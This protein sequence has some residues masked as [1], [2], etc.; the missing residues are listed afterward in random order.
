M[1]NFCCTPSACMTHFTCTSIKNCSLVKLYNKVLIIQL[2]D[3]C[4]RGNQIAPLST[5][6]PCFTQS[7]C[8][9]GA[10]SLPLSHLCSN[11]LLFPPVAPR[12]GDDG[13][14]CCYV[15]ICLISIANFTTHSLIILVP[16]INRAKFYLKIDMIYSAIVR[17]SKI[18]N[19][20]GLT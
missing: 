7:L 19:I 15:A 10:I 6:M 20:D 1:S 5:C 4:L 16:Q 12:C 17:T 13:N 18:Q 8:R 14:Q 11:S 2:L 9:R 3:K